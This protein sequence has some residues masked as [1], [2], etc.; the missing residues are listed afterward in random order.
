MVAALST[1]LTEWHRGTLPKHF[2]ASAPRRY[3]YTPRTLGYVRRKARSR[4]R[5]NPK[6]KKIDDVRPLQWTGVMRKTLLSG[7]SL[8]HKMTGR[9]ATVTLNLPYVRA[10]NLWTGRRVVRSTGVA[11]DLHREVSTMTGDELAQI[12]ARVEALTAQN[13]RAALNSAPMVEV[14]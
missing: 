5:G 14:A 11:H 2:E 7:V 3:G 10:A 12:A 4:Q 1:A 9:R 6:W 8:V 13:Y